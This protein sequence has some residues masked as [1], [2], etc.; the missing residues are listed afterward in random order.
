MTAKEHGGPDALIEDIREGAL[1]E[2]EMKGVLGSFLVIG[3]YFG[4]KWLLKKGKEWYIA[5][6]KGRASADELRAK[7]REYE[8]FRQKES[9]PEKGSDDAEIASDE[10]E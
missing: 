5:R 7:I 2:G 8:E 6:C 4:G 10:E 9:S 1:R 3:G